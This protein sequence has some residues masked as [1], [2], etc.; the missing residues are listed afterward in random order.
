MSK[1]IR[2]LPATEL[3]ERAQTTARLASTNDEARAWGAL[4]DV[5]LQELPAQA[6]WTFLLASSAIVAIPKYTTGTVSVNTGAT[7]ATFSAAASLPANLDQGRIRFNDNANVYAFTRTGAT[8]GT[9]SPTLSGDVNVSAGAYT[10]YMPTYALAADF[11]RFPKN[12]G[13]QVWQGAKPTAVPEVPLQEYYA[14]FTASPSVPQKCRLIAP[15]TAGVLRVE[16]GPPPDKAYLFPYDYFYTPPPLRESTGGVATVTAGAT[17]ATFQSTPRLGV[18]TSGWYFRL[19]A[20]G[21]GADSEWYRIQAVSEAQ[22]SVTF[23]N[24]FAGSAANSANYTLCM[25][26]QLPLVLQGALLHGVTKRL[27]ADQ[28]DE[29]FIYV[30]S[31]QTAAINDAK[32]LYRT[33]VYSQEVDTILTEFNYRR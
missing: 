33:R 17:G 2:E 11:D 28:S 21:T 29:T 23:L 32:R 20:N 10:L 18:V 30:D 16:L 27:L 4:N 19:D 12:G 26:P 1:T 15:D 7:A 25:V 5:Y 24:T 13:L 22:S 6:D 8:G 14:D 31:L 9:I 3:I